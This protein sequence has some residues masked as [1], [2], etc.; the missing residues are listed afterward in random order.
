M[1]P[2]PDSSGFDFSALVRSAADASSY[3]PGQNIVT[4]G[5]P[6]DCMF[7]L[8][9][10]TVEVLVGGRVLSTLGP[11]NLFG[12]MS[13]IN[14]EVRSA[15]IRAQSATRVVSLNRKRFLFLTEQTPFFALHVMRLLSQRL[16]NT[17]QLT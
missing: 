9:E 12:E 15:T 14:D 11:G 1:S 10:G 8:L 4:E 2:S 13:V 3:E 17:N 7:I 5:D 6:G 16:R